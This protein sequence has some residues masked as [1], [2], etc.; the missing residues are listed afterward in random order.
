M[1]I[2]AYTPLGKGIL[3]G[4]YDTEHLPPMNDYR[5]QRKYFAKENLPTFVGISVELK[6][7]AGDLS[8][9]PAQ[10]ALAWVISRTAVATALPGAKTIDQVRLNAAAADLVVPAE[11]LA[12][13]DEVSRT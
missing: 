13:L 5:H 2:L 1:G 9:T 12:R 10:L 4:K 8:C 7:L 3:S 11:V 6:R